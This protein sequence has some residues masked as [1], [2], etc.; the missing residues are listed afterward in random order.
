VAFGLG[1]DAVPAG[2][3]LLTAGV[4]L[5]PLVV[6]GPGRVRAA[7]L[8]A[9]ALLPPFPGFGAALALLGEA[10]D[11]MP[12]L[13][14][15]LAALMVAGAGGLARAALASWRVPAAMPRRDLLPAGLVLAGLIVAGMVPAAARW[16]E[17]VAE[18]L[19]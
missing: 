14:V 15:P 11:G 4:V 18:G 7:A 6:F 2:L 1:G 16:F 8:A 17:W 19:R 3:V 10:A 12:A 5:G 13:A 9:L